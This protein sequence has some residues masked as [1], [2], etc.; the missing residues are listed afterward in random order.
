MRLRGGLLTQPS[1]LRG[2]SPPHRPAATQEAEEEEGDVDVW[3]RERVAV[4]SS[5]E[6]DPPDQ[7][8]HLPAVRRWR[9]QHVLLVACRRRAATARSCC[10]EGGGG[11]EGCVLV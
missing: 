2:L 3:T 9:R 4:F 11:R 7:L 6:D 8:H 5:D 1:P 10:W